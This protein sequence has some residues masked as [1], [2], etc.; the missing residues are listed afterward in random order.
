[1]FGCKDFFFFPELNW[2]G[3]TFQLSYLF[4][5]LIKEFEI[6]KITDLLKCKPLI[7]RLH[8]VF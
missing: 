8:F 4:K 7:S 1:M 5:F 3:W 6:K 2:I